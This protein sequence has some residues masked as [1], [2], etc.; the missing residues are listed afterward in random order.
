MIGE[1][2]VK[3][4]TTEIK[5]GGWNLYGAAKFFCLATCSTE[6]KDHKVI[7]LYDSC[8]NVLPNT[9]HMKT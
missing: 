6:I 3:A 7:E 2:S 9:S 5:E 8:K 1:A 4:R